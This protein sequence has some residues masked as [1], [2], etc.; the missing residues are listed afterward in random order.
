MRRT[1]EPR[2]RRG[3]PGLGIRG[4][5]HR[6]RAGR[7]QIAAAVHDARPQA[8]RAIAALV[9]EQLR[10]EL[11]GELLRIDLDQAALAH[12]RRELADRRRLPRSCANARGAR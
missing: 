12:H 4:R 9:A 10:L 5:A 3:E 7:E 2:Q 6:H 11:R 1:G 8:E